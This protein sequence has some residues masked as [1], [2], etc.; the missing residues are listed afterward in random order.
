MMSILLT[1]QSYSSKLIRVQRNSTRM[2]LHFPPKPKIHLSTVELTAYNG[3]DIPVKVTFVANV[4]YKDNS[5]VPVMF[6]IA[7]TISTPILHL[8]TGEE[9][10]LIKREMVVDSV[11]DLYQNLVTKFSKCVGELGVQSRE[12]HITLEDDVKLV[13][14]PPR[15]TPIVLKD[16]L[17]TELD[18]MVKNDVN[19]P[20]LEPTDWVNSPVIVEK[21]NG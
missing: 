9:L 11:H 7:D 2:F 21:C 8:P 15:I 16:Q 6:D 10:N 18:I 4:E 5:P 3:S 19:A 1:G 20:I 12:Y 17:K 13:A 14:M